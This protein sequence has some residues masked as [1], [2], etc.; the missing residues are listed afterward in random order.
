MLISKKFLLVSSLC[1]MSYGCLVS[2]EKSDSSYEEIQ[3]P[4][5]YA[6]PQKPQEKIS[7][8]A[9]YKAL[10]EDDYDTWRQF[11]HDKEMIEQLFIE[12]AEKGSPNNSKKVLFLKRSFEKKEKEKIEAL[13]ALQERLDQC[14]ATALWN[15]DIRIGIIS[16]A[17]MVVGIL[18]TMAFYRL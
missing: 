2:N 15:R 4:N 13:N 18:G 1:L 16:S 5:V 12:S 17:A 6:G 8:E 9:A 14:Q 7:K 3:K 11:S 10:D